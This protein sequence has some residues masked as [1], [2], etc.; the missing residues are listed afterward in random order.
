[1]WMSPRD[2]LKEGEGQ[3]A[4]GCTFHTDVMWEWK[5]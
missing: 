4:D 5:S 1:M 3:E 2:S